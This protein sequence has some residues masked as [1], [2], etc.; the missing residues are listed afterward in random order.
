MILWANGLQGVFIN[1]I[2]YSPSCSVPRSC[3]IQ[4]LKIRTRIP[5]NKQNFWSFGSHSK[6]ITVISVRILSICCVSFTASYQHFY[7][8]LMIF[9]EGERQGQTTSNPHWADLAHAGRQIW[10]MFVLTD[11]SDGHCCNDTCQNSICKRVMDVHSV[12]VSWNKL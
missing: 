1:Q 9:L 12:Q 2:I 5:S 8:S 6:K 11:I 3:S 4:S 7:G 10:Q